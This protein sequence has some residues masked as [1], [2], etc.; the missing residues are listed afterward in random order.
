MN[1]AIGGF[2][3]NIHD[4]VIDP[5]VVAYVAA[6]SL[7]GRLIFPNLPIPR[8]LQIVYRQPPDVRGCSPQLL[9]P[10]IREI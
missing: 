8:R 7:L 4:H 6:S 5:L 3:R 10:E 2:G 1:Q 9:S